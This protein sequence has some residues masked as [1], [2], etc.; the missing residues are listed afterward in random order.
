MAK[1][2]A[3]TPITMEDIKITLHS[4]GLGTNKDFTPEHAKAI[5]AFQEAKGITKGWTKDLPAESTTP[6][7]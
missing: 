5:L 6:A 7:E 4:Q 3:V 2:S 1:Q